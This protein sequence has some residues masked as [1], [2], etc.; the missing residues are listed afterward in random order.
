MS[1]IY[2]QTAYFILP[3]SNL[4]KRNGK[5]L[6]YVE[7]EIDQQCD[8][9]LPKAV[10]KRVNEYFNIDYYSDIP[11]ISYFTYLGNISGFKGI[12]RKSLNTRNSPD[13]ALFRV[14]N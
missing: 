7:S 11:F 3:K 6:S 9:D 13:C 5:S 1:N 8:L 12:D 14:G 2:T 10:E 4:F